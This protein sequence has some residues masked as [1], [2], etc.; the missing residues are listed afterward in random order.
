MKST[1]YIILL[2]I[3]SIGQAQDQ[4]PTFEWRGQASLFHAS[5]LQG[6][7]SESPTTLRYIP[8]F[9]VD[10]QIDQRKRWGFDGAIDLYN[11]SIGDSLTRMDV[12][13]YRFTLRYDTPNTQIRVGLQKINFGP[14]R[15][16]RVLQW[17]DQLDPRDPLALSS[18][19]WAIMGRHYFEG[20]GNLRI[21]TMAD[22]PDVTRSYWPAEDSWPWD[23]GA[24][25]EYPIPAGTFGLTVHR[26]DV[27]NVSDV[28]ENRFAG[29]VRVD[30]IVGLWSEMMFA[31]IED[32]TWVMDAFS[33]MAG[34]DYTFGI[35]NGLYAALEMA[36]TYQGGSGDEMPWQ[37]RTLALTGNYTLGLSDGLTFYLYALDFPI[38]DS[39]IIPMLG[40]Q[41]TRGNWLV[42][43]AL[44]N[45]PELASGGG[46]ALPAGNGVQL[47]IAF[48]H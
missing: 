38:R 36:T 17:F 25:L 8:Q 34:V 33:I 2:A 9:R 45:M 5:A 35:G 14:A 24:R 16:L 10:Y 20:G 18:G 48:N 31:R 44:Y 42:Y 12:D 11:H 6:S 40:W 41:H 7:F 37:V 43:V 1:L 29:D 21:W 32:P 22:A 27:S 19:V 23:V 30:A 4:A 26:L 28:K 15:M 3:F 39:Q 13:F 46:M 47:N